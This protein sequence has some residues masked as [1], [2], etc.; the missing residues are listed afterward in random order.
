MSAAASPRDVPGSLPRARSAPSGAP[1]HTSSVATCHAVHAHLSAHPTWTTARQS[2]T[3]S[4]DSLFRSNPHESVRDPRTGTR[5][6]AARNIRHHRHRQAPGWRRHQG[7]H[8]RRQQ[9]MACSLARYARATLSQRL[10]WDV[11][12]TRPCSFARREDGKRYGK[13]TEEDV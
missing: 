6:H 11:L 13:A 4:L 1:L 12:L 8:K 3:S 9:M 10:W 7:R 5:S 2:R